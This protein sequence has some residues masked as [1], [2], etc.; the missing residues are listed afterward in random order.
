MNK[1][2][3]EEERIDKLEKC[4]RDKD[5]RIKKLEEYFCLRNHLILTL[6]S[7]ILCFLPYAFMFFYLKPLPESVEYPLS[8]IIFGVIGI[9]TTVVVTIGSWLW[10][11][12]KIWED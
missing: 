11:M 5:K 6:F 1:N 4:V 2:N 8:L 3:V 7:T 9:I 10:L 12:K